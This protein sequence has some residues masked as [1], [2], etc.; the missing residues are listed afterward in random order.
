MII[1]HKMSTYVCV[2]KHITKFLLY[3]VF[4]YMVSAPTPGFLPLAPCQASAGPTV[5][6]V[7]FQHSEQDTANLFDVRYYDDDRYSNYL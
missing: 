4:M 1:S 5:D 7:I 2:M 3:S 6:M